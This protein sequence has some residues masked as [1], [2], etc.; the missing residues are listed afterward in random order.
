[1][2]CVSNKTA[3]SRFCSLPFSIIFI[4]GD[5]YAYQAAEQVGALNVASALVA[6]R[7]SAQHCP[8]PFAFSF[9]E[10]F[11]SQR[12]HALLEPAKFHFQIP[13][14]ISLLAA[15][16]LFTNLLSIDSIHHYIELIL[17]F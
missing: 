10:D 1:M 7:R 2:L 5:S 15:A 6:Y 9:G 11:V 8:V 3:K 4:T 16:V 17:P 12:V 14:I 13:V